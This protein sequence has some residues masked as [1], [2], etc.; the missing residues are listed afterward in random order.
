MCKLI[1]QV[2][3][4]HSSVVCGEQAKKYRVHFSWAGEWFARAFAEQV[5][6]DKLK[7]EEQETELC[8]NYCI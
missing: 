2:L 4:D 5:T 6:L 7:L 1:S 8:V 3:E